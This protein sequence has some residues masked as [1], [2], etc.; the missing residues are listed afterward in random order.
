MMDVFDASHME[1]CGNSRMGVDCVCELRWLESPSES[2][3]GACACLWGNQAR[4]MT[5]SCLVSMIIGLIIDFPIKITNKSPN[6]LFSIHEH[7]EPYITILHHL[8][9][10]QENRSTF[11]FIR[12]GDL[13][14][15]P[16]HNI[17]FKHSDIT[18]WS[19]SICCLI[20]NI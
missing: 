4:G 19:F 16:C 1:S 6:R 15:V 3:L 17:P 14:S 5:T 18:R 10:S 11:S 20:C 7:M 13:L 2:H 12:W 9:Y 8:L